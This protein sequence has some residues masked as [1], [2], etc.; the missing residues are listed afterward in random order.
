MK[1]LD[2]KLLEK[3][4]LINVLSEK[5]Y[6]SE[7][8]TLDVVIDYSN[9]DYNL[10][11]KRCDIVVANG[12]RSIKLSDTFSLG[13]EYL[14][15]GTLQL[16]PIAFSGDDVVKFPI[17]SIFV[18]ES[19]N[20][21]ENDTTVTLSIAEEMLNDIELFK[22]GVDGELVSQNIKIDGL[23]LDTDT[24]LSEQDVI[25]A[26]LTS[27]LEQSRTELDVLNAMNNDKTWARFNVQAEIGE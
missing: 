11:N 5:V 17:T 1:K 25:I 21:L 4:R 14:V 2:I 3:G 16:Q 26:D 19:L 9:T 15:K 13:R 23:L 12:Q 6:D 7:N 22:I 18:S 20:V 8:E 24:R 27:Q 10:W